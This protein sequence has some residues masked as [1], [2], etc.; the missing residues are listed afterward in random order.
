MHGLAHRVFFFDPRR[1]YMPVR[2]EQRSVSK[3]LPAENMESFTQMYGESHIV[4]VVAAKR[5]GELWVP[6]KVVTLYGTLE[7]ETERILPRQKDEMILTEST[8]ECSSF[9]RGEVTAKDMQLPFPRG[10]FVYDAMAHVSYRITDSGSFETYRQYDAVLGRPRKPS[11]QELADALLVHP[12]GDEIPLETTPER[13]AAIARMD[14]HNFAQ[15]LGFMRRFQQRAPEFP[16]NADWLNGPR[17]ELD[18]LRGQFVLLVFFAEWCGP[19]RSELPLAV[20]AHRNESNRGIVVIG[21]HTAG[22]RRRD[23]EKFVNDMRLDFPI[24]VDAAFDDDDK[25]WGQMC[26]M[27]G[28]DALPQA[29]LI[30]PDGSLVSRGNILDL[31]QTARKL[32][33]K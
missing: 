17:I 8:C 22:S 3:E 19:C 11:A 15:R 26:G 20:A 5:V 9:T 2:Y 7:R 33:A 12:P 27:F 21:V 4:D 31:L 18:K 1:D 32:N 16:S 13:E 28:V 29:V 14:E 10:T 23:V 30:G 6:I 24:C 25:S